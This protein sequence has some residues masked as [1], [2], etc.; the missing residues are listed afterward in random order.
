[1][2]RLLQANMYIFFQAASF[3]RKKSEMAVFVFSFD[4]AWYN[5]T[6]D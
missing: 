2:N 1:M 4:S 6:R 3:S 5:R